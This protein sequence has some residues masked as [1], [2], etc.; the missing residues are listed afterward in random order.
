LLLVEAEEAGLVVRV[1]LLVSV[2]MLPERVLLLLVRVLMPLVDVRVGTLLAPRIV[3]V[4]VS[5]TVQKRATPRW[6]SLFH[7]YMV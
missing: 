2:R 5:N 3:V 6:S 1:G 7:Y 4:L